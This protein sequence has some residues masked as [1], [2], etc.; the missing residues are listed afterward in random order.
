MHLHLMH[1]WSIMMIQ[2]LHSGADSHSPGMVLS[3][4]TTSF[5]CTCRYTCIR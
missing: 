1:S 5:A 3:I 2:I 4:V